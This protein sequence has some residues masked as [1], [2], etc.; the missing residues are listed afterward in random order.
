MTA[1]TQL[2][3]QG[4]TILKSV[5]DKNTLTELNSLVDR[6]IAYANQELVDPF[7]LYYLRH[8][9]DQGVLYDLYQRHPEFHPFARNSQVLDLLE[10]VLGKDIFMY[11][12]SLVYKPRGAANAVPWHQDFISRPNEPKKFI[13]WMALDNIHQGNG[14]L[15]VIPSSHKMGYLPWHRVKGETHHDRLNLDSVDESSAQFV[16][17][18]AGDVLVFDAM[19]VHSSEEVDVAEPRRAYRVSYQGFEQVMT[20]RGSPIVMRGGQPESLAKRFSSK[21]STSRTSSMRIFLR[22]VG[23]KLA[24]L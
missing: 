8:R 7:E 1:A 10:N 21:H 16:E 19:L 12:N 14:A 3:D 9:N 5:F 4:F 17:L 18:V 11:E 13:I 2:T 22:N 23:K 6:I 15:K 24:R 20:P